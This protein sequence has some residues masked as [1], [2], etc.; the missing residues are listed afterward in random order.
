MLSAS[1]IKA[2][3]TVIELMDNKNPRIQLDSATEVLDRTGIVKPDVSTA[4]QVNVFN[5]LKEDSEEF[6]I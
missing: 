3:Q 5:K 4:L 1:A 2:S 6:G